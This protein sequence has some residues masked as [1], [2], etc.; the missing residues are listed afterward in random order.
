MGIR[1]NLW[2]YSYISTRNPLFNELADKG[3]LLKT[4]DRRPVYSPLVP[5][6]I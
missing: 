4:A 6:A 5:V 3:Y 1:L 2:E